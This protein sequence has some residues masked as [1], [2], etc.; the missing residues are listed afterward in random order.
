ME[1]DGYKILKT[2]SKDLKETF[3]KQSFNK[4]GLV[5]YCVNNSTI[6]AFR[7][8][9][10]HV[11]KYQPLSIFRVWAY[12][13][14]EDTKFLNALNDQ[15]NFQLLRKKTLKDLKSYWQKEDGGTPPFYLFNKLIDLFFKNLP[16][17]NE[18][19]KETKEWI[20]KNTNVPLDKF[21]LKSLKEFNP[22][23]KIPKTVSMNF[24]NEGNYDNLQSEIKQIC[25][26]IP[27]IIFDLYAWDES[28]KIEKPFELVKISIKSE[29]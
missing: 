28:H 18:L 24:V 6:R 8:K 11:K 17:W 4:H 27:P 15:K 16:L 20:F 23:I 29:K 25:K 1:V 19:G 21:S 13:L 14:L 2:K 22:T 3:Y 7:E 9:K 12:H 5:I 26:D 10:G